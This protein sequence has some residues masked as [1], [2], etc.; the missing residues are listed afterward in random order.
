LRKAAQSGM[1]K[2]EQSTT[3][4]RGP[5]CR[6]AAWAWAVVQRSN[7]RNNCSDSLIR[8]RQ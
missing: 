6:V 1:E 3:M 8:A 2:L 7:Q 4:T 5:I